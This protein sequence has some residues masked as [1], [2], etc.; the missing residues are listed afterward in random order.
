MLHSYLKVRILKC[1]PDLKKKQQNAEFLT[2]NFRNF[3]LWVNGS[4][5]E[6]GMV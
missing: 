3:I 5:V 4:R 1:T 2:D 6:L